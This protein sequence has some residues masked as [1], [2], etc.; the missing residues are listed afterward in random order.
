MASDGS[1]GKVRLAVQRVNSASLLMDNKD[2][3]ST[4]ANG[5]ICYISF[6]TLCTSEDL[7]KVAKAIAHLPVATLGAW[8][9]GSKPRSIRDF[10]Q[11]GKSMGL[12]LVPQAGMVSKIKGKTLQYR[13]Q[14]NK[15]VGRT[16]YEEFCHLI[17]RCIVDEQIEVTTSSNNAEKKNKRVSPDVPAHELFRTH[18]TQDYTE[19]DD[20][21]IPTVKVTGEA[22]SK[23]Q[24]KKLVKT[25]KAQDK[26]YQ[27]WLKNPEQYTAEI[28]E[29]AAV[30]A[31]AAAAAV[32]AAA[33]VAPGA[34][35]P[36]TKQEEG[37]HRNNANS[38][39]GHL[40]L[41]PHFTLVTGTF[42]NRQGL[43]L[44]AA[45]GPNLHAYSFS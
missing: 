11:E 7:P 19:F 44:N 24:R 4:M 17:V 18:Y 45:C 13:N 31:A 3:W 33:S 35:K 10:I 23:S 28:A 34:E 15:D 16:L 29:I 39:G 2:T 32:A 41:P 5:L 37:N 12:M 8:G 1:S 20:E 26:K 6:T 42:G 36:E 14:A 22:I 21:G 9:D 27:K 25:M 30:A 43:Q 38:K 40:E